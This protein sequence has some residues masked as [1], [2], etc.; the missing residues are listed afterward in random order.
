MS[1][2]TFC[3]ACHHVDSLAAW[4]QGTRKERERANNAHLG[5]S[6]CFLVFEEYTAPAQLLWGMD[7]D[8]RSREEIFTRTSPFPNKPGDFFF[9]SEHPPALLLRAFRDV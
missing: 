7:R 2:T 1:Q 5:A 8:K 6:R 9:F 4:L 3:C